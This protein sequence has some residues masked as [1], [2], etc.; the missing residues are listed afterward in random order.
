MSANAQDL[1]GLSL[2]Q[3]Q[4]IDV[5]TAS[6]F[7]QGIDEVLVIAR[8]SGRNFY[9]FTPTRLLL[10]KSFDFRGAHLGTIY[11]DADL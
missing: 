7:T 9:R 10:G 5:V 6:K 2:D 11:I 3:L 1:T 4:H 8:Y